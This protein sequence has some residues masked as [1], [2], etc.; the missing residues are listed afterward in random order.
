MPLGRQ[1]EFHLRSGR[2]DRKWKAITG[3]VRDVAGFGI[4][5]TG[6]EGVLELLAAA[7]D[8]ECDAQTQN[9]K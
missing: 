2:K 5:T 9:K 3:D 1:R 4:V 8:E 6:S 7:S